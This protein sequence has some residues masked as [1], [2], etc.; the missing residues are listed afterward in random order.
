MSPAYATYQT[1]AMRF[2]TKN[3][4]VSCTHKSSSKNTLDVINPETILT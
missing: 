1:N 2:T 4:N 3:Q